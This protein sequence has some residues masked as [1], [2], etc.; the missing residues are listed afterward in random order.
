MNILIREE[1]PRGDLDKYLPARYASLVKKGGDGQRVT[2]VC[3]P[4]DQTVITVRNVEKALKNINNPQITALYFAR[5][6]SLEAL[7]YIEGT[8]GAAFSLIAYPWT[9]ER[10]RQVRGG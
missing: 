9:E 4:V 10:Y 1:I 8:N 3:F 5:C 2:C 7:R 6:F